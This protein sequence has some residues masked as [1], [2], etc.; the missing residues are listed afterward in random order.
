MSDC[1]VKH[2]L[3][4]HFDPSRHKVWIDYNLGLAT[5]PLYDVGG[6]LRGYQQYNPSTTNKKSN[7]P[8][9]SRYFT[10][11]RGTK[12]TGMGV[13]WG[14]DS[15]TNSRGT[16]F[17]TEGVFESARL[18]SYGY[19]SVAILTSCPP[20]Q[21]VTQLY[22]LGYETLVWC[23]DADK[24]GRRSKVIKMVDEVMFFEVDLDEV[25]EEELLEK[26]YEY[27]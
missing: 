13:V 3:K 12:E 23:G 22:G 10:Y 1:I 8:R 21:T 26:L 24:A 4:R 17:L 5:F 18:L 7:D 20:V 27:N 6:V 2:L 16:L 11:H 15:L 14:L 25:P 19:D 9:E